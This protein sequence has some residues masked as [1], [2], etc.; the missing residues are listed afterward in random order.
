MFVIEAWIKQISRV[1][2]RKCEDQNHSF[3]N[4]VAQP[5]NVVSAVERVTIKY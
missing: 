3:N 5:I 1:C 4:S 2:L